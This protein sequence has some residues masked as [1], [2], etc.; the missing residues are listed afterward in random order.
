MELLK[1]YREVISYCIFGAGTTLVNL[2]VYYLCAHPLGIDTVIS[3]GMAWLLSVLFA[4]VT[5]KIWVF[6]SHVTGGTAIVKELVSFFACRFLTGV[7]DV[8]MMHLFVDEFHFPDMWMK[9][10]ANIIVIVVNFVASKLLIFRK[11][12]G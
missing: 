5:N 11:N 9:I 4:Y 2:I 1:K 7:L 8:G 6:E 12:K 10:L 3:T